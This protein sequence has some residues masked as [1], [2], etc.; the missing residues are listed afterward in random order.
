MLTLLQELC[1][2]LR[3][4]PLKTSRATPPL[5]LVAPSGWLFCDFSRCICDKYQFMCVSATQLGF[6]VSVYLVPKNS[7]KLV[8]V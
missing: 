2:G 6:R 8:F 5:G 1:K 7:A 4:N 3:I